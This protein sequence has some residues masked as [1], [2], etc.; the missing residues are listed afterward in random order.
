MID[1]RRQVS[2]DRTNNGNDNRMISTLIDSLRALNTDFKPPTF[3]DS[4]NPHIFLEKLNKFFKLK[5]IP[6]NNRLDCLD[7]VF[8]GRAKIWHETQEYENYN[9][10][11]KKFMDEFNSIPVR[12]RYK[13]KWLAKAF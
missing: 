12:V 13:S 6:N 7:E 9:D 2:D 4:S 3:D 1:L 5:R 10:F 11:T 8:E